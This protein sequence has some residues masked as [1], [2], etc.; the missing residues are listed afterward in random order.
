MSTDQF[1]N[2]TLLMQQGNIKVFENSLFRWLCFEDEQAIQSC[3]LKQD[4]S[5]L[6]LAYQPF[7]MM[8]S[9]L[10]DTTP[11]TACLFG[12]GGGDIARYM[13]QQFPS[14]NLL[15]VEKS[16]DVAK[17]ASDYFHIVP[18][19]KQ[20]TVQI[21]SAENLLQIHDSYELLLID[22]VVNNVLPDFLYT[23]KFWS[24]CRSK[25]NKHSVVVMNVI[26]ESEEKFVALLDVMRAVFG[27]LPLCMGVPD[28]KNIILMLAASADVMKDISQIKK[29]SIDLQKKS[30]LPYRQCIKILEKDNSISLK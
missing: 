12:L 10:V 2:P 1:S 23:N 14:M 20:L 18:D 30:D 25:F 29:R 9:L 3:M 24:D 27:Y 8:W 11:S 5:L 28:H 17:V 6:N 19:Q 13:R 26:S 4:P 7:M 16:P 21:D 15:V 22:V